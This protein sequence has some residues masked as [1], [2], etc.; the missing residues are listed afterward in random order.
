M[1]V[2]A[3]LSGTTRLFDCSQW[4]AMPAGN[5]GWTLIQ[6]DCN[7]ETPTARRPFAEVGPPRILPSKQV[8][9]I[10]E[11]NPITVVTANGVA[12]IGLLTGDVTAGSLKITI[13]DG[14]GAAVGGDVVIDIDEAQILLQNLGGLLALTQ[15]AQGGAATGQA[16]IWNGSAWVPDYVTGGDDW[17]AQ[18]VEVT[19]RLSGDGTVGNELDIA[20]QGAT[21][22]QV[23][24]WSGSAWAPTTPGTGVP[25]GTDT[26]TIRYNG[27]TPTAV[28]NLTNDGTY[29]GI[30][31]APNTSY[32]LR[33]KQSGSGDGIFFERSGG[34]NG[35]AIYHDNS[36]AGYK[37]TGG[38]AHNFYNANTLYFAVETARVAA[39]V[40]FVSAWARVGNSTTDFIVDIIPTLSGTQTNPLTMH[41]IK[42]VNSSYTNTGG[43]IG[44]DI[45]LSNFSSGTIYGHLV[46]SGLSGFGTATPVARL[47]VVGLG[48]TSSTDAFRV[49]DGAGTPAIIFEIRDDKRIGILTTSPAL[50]LDAIA[51]TDGF[52]LPTGTTAQ[53]T[54]VNSSLREN[55]TV[56]G[57]EVRE[58]GAWKRLTSGNA[59]TI[60]AGAA[61]G[62]SPTVSV[63]SGNDLCHQITITPG[64]SPTTGALCTV[65]FAQSLDPG[66]FTFVVFSPAS[67]SAIGVG[68]LSSAGNTAYTLSTPTALTTGT[69]YTFHV[70]VK[71]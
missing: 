10:L 35:L 64:T 61:L 46:R 67:D 71:Q 26:Q 68:R 34:S 50:T 42:P 23:L 25:S 63:D 60:T 4:D 51:A 45:D 17:G 56:G 5:L 6:R 20:Q 62:T 29:I 32:K 55:S 28:S 19:A 59:P 70:M 37:T 27:T 40:K 58:A 43:L 41:H 14:T 33:V 21:A 38:T 52:G 2:K 1:P 69:A 49:Y 7:G 54:S 30:G 66:I 13:T 11:Q 22:G 8:L 3:A 31:G 16:L 47:G 36:V 44:M 53:R 39:Y 12:T 48:T 57:L 18:V 9:D 24:A 15:I 65:T